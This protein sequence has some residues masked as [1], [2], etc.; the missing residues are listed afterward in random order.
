MLLQF[1]DV[2]RPDNLHARDHARRA[3]ADRKQKR[4]KEP[5]QPGVPQWPYKPRA[6]SFEELRALDLATVRLRDPW[7]PTAPSAP[8]K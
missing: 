4:R 1:P 2:E 7:P 8:G 3:V 5:R 6:L